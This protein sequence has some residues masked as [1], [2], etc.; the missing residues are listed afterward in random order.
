[1]PLVPNR[2][3]E[4]PITA[5]EPPDDLCE[6][7]AS[8]KVRLGFYDAP[9]QETF[10]IEEER[11]WLSHTGR[12]LRRETIAW[13]YEIAGA[14]PTRYT[15]ELYADV[16]LPK[17]SGRGAPKLVEREVATYYPWT[18]WDRKGG[19]S[20]VK[21]L[22]GYVI[23]DRKPTDTA[24]TADELASLADKGHNTTGGNRLI[25]SS[26]RLWSEALHSG[27]I[28]EAA[29]SPQQA[30][31]VEPVETEAE[32]VVDQ[33][34][35]Y[36]VYRW[37][38]NH[39]RGGDVEIDGPEQRE[40]PSYT[41]RLPV[42]VEPPSV[43][44]GG[45]GDDGLR[46]EITGG[47]ATV[48]TIRVHPE[49]YRLERRVISEPAR[50]Q[51]EDPYALWNTDPVAPG[52]AARIWSDTAVTTTAGVP[53]AS[54]KPSQTSYTEPGD[55]TEE[56]DDGWVVVAEPA[57]AAPAGDEGSAA[58]TDGEVVNSGVYEYRAVAVIGS[59]ESP[60]S[61]PVRYTYTGGDRASSI[62]VRVR[63]VTVGDRAGETEVDIL[64]PDPAIAI[65]PDAL[66]DWSDEYGE[67]VI[68]DVPTSYEG[69]D[70]TAFGEAVGTRWFEETRTAK[71]A[72]EIT[73]AG[74][75]L[76]LDRG[77]LVATPT[78]EWTTTGNG[79]RI[80]SELTARDWVVDGWSATFRRGAS[81]ELDTVRTVL[82]VLEP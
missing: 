55:T 12:V 36:L 40:K 42:A 73:L 57:N 80:T 61:T 70:L 78:H 41:Y 20:A 53:V 23:Y 74:P 30:V 35:T 1:M 18:N 79:L 24:R 63:E 19:L 82:K 4:D 68:L 67:V 28:I 13:E 65:D 47:G 39:I 52:S 72:A 16:Y 21:K 27:R 54:S 29:D 15:R 49:R 14:P 11:T 6:G 25:V 75:L 59:D 62:R 10:L 66:G 56:E 45:A 7:T 3:T 8:L 50:T 38:Q 51:D 81:G 22:S 48:S 9:G 71:T 33:A 31:W 5:F 58:V 43:D 76:G 64:A 77:M 60:P 26:A 46:I 34:N 69:D 2:W 44:V 32:V 37:R 17:V